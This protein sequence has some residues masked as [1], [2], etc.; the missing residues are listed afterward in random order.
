MW[1]PLVIH[2]DRTG[3]KSMI[4]FKKACRKKTHNHKQRRKAAKERLKERR[5]RLAQGDTLPR[6]SVTFNKLVEADKNKNVIQEVE[7]KEVDKIEWEEDQTFILDHIYFETGSS[8]L[9]A[10]SY[11][12]LDELAD[13]L[14]RNE[15]SII[16]IAGHTDNIGDE[17]VNEKLS[18]ERVKSVWY[19][20]T[21][22]KGIKRNRLLVKGYGSSNPIASNETREGRKQNRRVEFTILKK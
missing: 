11:D 12:Q 13:W 5:R 14:I 7:V 3:N 10:D 16:E 6:R 15:N 17:S 8:Q 20:L 21:K 19:Y 9:L 18:K 2:A 22:V 1:P 4:C